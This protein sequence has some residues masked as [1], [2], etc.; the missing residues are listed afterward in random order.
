M[1]YGLTYHDE[2]IVTPRG[3]RSTPIPKPAYVSSTASG[4]S[5]LLL[6]MGIVGSNLQGVAVGR[7]IATGQALTE[8]YSF[9]RR[10]KL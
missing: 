6:I 10:Q 2:R 5:T 4:R 8:R 7:H 3:P 1:R 9:R